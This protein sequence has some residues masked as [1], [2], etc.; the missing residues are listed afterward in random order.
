VITAHRVMGP[1]LG[2]YGTGW[3][4]IDDDGKVLIVVATKAEAQRIVKE[5]RV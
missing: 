4:I 5:Q 1:T 3:E 2:T